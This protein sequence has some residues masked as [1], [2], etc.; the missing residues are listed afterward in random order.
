MTETRKWSIFLFT[1]LFFLSWAIKIA[2]A[3]VEYHMIWW[4]V[5]GGFSVGLALVNL[6][7]SMGSDRGRKNRSKL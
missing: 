3:T 1:G 2:I 4:L 5:G 7:D 6:V